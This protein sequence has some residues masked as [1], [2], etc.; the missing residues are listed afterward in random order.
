MKG[1]QKVLTDRDKGIGYEY[2]SGRKEK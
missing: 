2:K 1:L